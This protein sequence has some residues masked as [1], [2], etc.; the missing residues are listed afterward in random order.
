MADLRRSRTA[1]PGAAAGRR[2]RRPSRARVDWLLLGAALAL[3][4]FGL[5]AIAGITRHDI[6]GDESYFVVRQAFFAG[7]G[8]VALTVLAIAG[9]G[10]LAASGG[11]STAC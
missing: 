9:P 3:V 5:W 6:P 8:L 2:R 10:V 11:S 7:A 1:T 4:A